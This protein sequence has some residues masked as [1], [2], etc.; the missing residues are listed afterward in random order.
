MA[1]NNIT[2]PDFA[3]PVNVRQNADEQYKIAIKN[4]DEKAALRALVDA[5]L[6]QTAIAPDSA[7]S[8]ANRIE[9]FAAGCKNPAVGSL[10][11][12]F[13]AR[14]YND[15]YSSNRWV[16]NSRSLPEA[17]V[18]SDIQAWDGKM[19]RNKINS[20][21]DSATASLK[22][23]KSVPVTDFKALVT[24]PSDARPFFPTL[25]DFV[26][27]NVIELKTSMLNSNAQLPLS[28]LSISATPSALKKTRPEIYAILHL[29]DELID[30]SR[31]SAAP[32]LYWT[33]EK[34]DFVKDRVYFSGNKE[35]EN[36]YKEM[37]KALFNKYST[38]Q[39]C[40][41]PLNS[42][43]AESNNES[44]DEEKEIYGY[45]KATVAKYPNAPLTNCLKNAMGQLARKSIEINH[46]S[47]LSPGGTLEVKISARNTPAAQLSLYRLPDDF[48][49][50]NN[51]VR[52]VAGAVKTD[53]KSVRFSGEVPFR[54]SDTVGFTIDQP[55]RYV[56]VPSFSGAS[57]TRESYPVIHVSALSAGAFMGEKNKVV[58]VE[59]VSGAPVNDAEIIG[60]RRRGNKPET[61]SLG[62]TDSNGFTIIPANFSGNIRPVK[63]ADRFAGTMYVYEK[64]NST[65]R[66]FSFINLFCDLPVY[67][68]GDSVNWACVAYS[69]AGKKKEVLSGKAVKVIFIDANRTPID[70]AT[71][72]TDALGRASGTFS[73]PEGLLTGRFS[74]RASTVEK[75]IDAQGYMGVMVSDYKLPTYILDELK[76][77]NDT[78]EKGSTTFTGI[79]KTFSGVPLAGISVKMDI[80]LLP[81]WW[82]ASG[83]SEKFYSDETVTDES[84]RF[85]FTV[86]I[87]DYE[88]APN[89]SGAF[90]AYFTATSATGESATAQK[91]FTLGTKYHIIANLPADMDISIPV[92]LNAYACDAEG[93]PVKEPVRFSVVADKDT[94]LRGEFETGNTVDL[95]A[96]PSGIYTFIFD[97]D[98]AAAEGIGNIAVYRPD[99]AMPP[100]NAT[101]W[102][103][104]KIVTDG[105][106]LLI[107]T[108]N[109]VT[110]VLYTIVSKDRTMKQEWL[111]YSPRMHRLEVNLPENAEDAQL[112]LFS[113]ADYKSTTERIRIESRKPSNSI[114]I[115]TETWRD[116]LIPGSKETI[117][118]KVTGADS[119][120]V[121]AA[122]MLDMFN[123]AL[124]TFSNHSLDFNPQTG[125]VPETDFKAPR[126]F[127]YSYTNLYSPFSYLTCTD[128]FTPELNT[129][130]RSFNPIMIRGGAMKL[131]GARSMA[132]G[133]AVSEDAA[134]EPEAVLMESKVATAVT[135]DMAKEESVEEEADAGSSENYGNTDNFDYRDS[136]VPLAF[137]NPMLTTD[138]NGNLSYTFTVPNAN[139]SWILSALAYTTDLRTVTVYKTAIASKPIM[140]TPNL[141]RFVR[142]G[143]EIVIE[144]QVFNTTDNAVNA[145]TTVEIINPQT[146]K[147][148]QTE[149]YRNEIGANSS[150]KV[151]TLLTAATDL[152]FIC[153]R[154]KASA[155]SYADGEQ[156][157][158]PVLP[159]SSP[160]IEST[161]FYIPA[162]ENQFKIQLPKYGNDARVTFTYC[163]NP[164]WY[165]VTALPELQKTNP[166]GAIEV[167]NNIFS[168]AVAQGIVKKYPSI[169]EALEFWR[170][171]PSD[172]ILTSMLERNGDMKSLLLAATP[173][174][175]DA[176][177]DSERMTRLALLLDNKECDNTIKKS[178]KTLTELQT[179][180]GG[181][182]W[183]K[184][185]DR[186]SLWVT[187]SVLK[188]L[189]R[190]NALGFMP[191]DTEL[192]KLIDNGLKYI[193]RE[194]TSIYNKYPDSN[195]RSYAETV[196]LFPAFN[197]STIGRSM[198]AVSTQR[199]VKDWKKMT[200]A[201]KAN[202]AL[203]L[204]R[205]GNKA[206][207]VTILKSLDEYATVT[208]ERG[209]WWQSLNDR[210]ASL[211]SL[212]ATASA[213][214]AYSTI[215]PGVQQ[216]E[217]INQWLILQKQATNW[218]NTAS[219][220]ET[221]AAIL[222]STPQWVK[223]DTDVKIELNE[224]TISTAAKEYTGE[225]KI[226][227]DPRKAS[228]GVL[229]IAKSS[230]APA[231]GGVISFE[232]K[233]M[234]SVKEADC[235]LLSISKKTLVKNGG[236]WKESDTF[237]VGDRVKISLTVT[238]GGVIDYLAITDSRAACLEPVEQL[239]APIW[240]DGICFYREN[241][242]SST[243]IFIDRL[244]KGTFVLEY[245]MWVNNSGE[246]SS[247]IATAQSQYA[248]EIT[249][250]SAGKILTVTE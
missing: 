7:G 155:E 153:F 90:S 226:N 101:L 104:K 82:R 162:D 243:N 170:N 115:S 195:F 131:Y 136:E 141:P 103:P 228:K 247:G 32:Y 84:G 197:P 123:S 221:V 89:T 88:L 175:Q 207:A 69:A 75:D 34:L 16:F 118:F 181:I 212:I 117:T 59:P 51:Y 15:V 67:H 130:N 210:S 50:L 134:E 204:F 126:A 11:Y 215:T 196:S 128:I 62:K 198:I 166:S 96:L 29:Y 80:S 13:T 27:S 122:M 236:E 180:D 248:P 191:K 234:R 65:N 241:R 169:G 129:Y 24:V 174:M 119:A 135:M 158:I 219:T 187:T 186:P 159:S 133:I 184:Q 86:S 157:I 8:M 12:L 21:C 73:I 79:A 194:Y 64:Y 45:I 33:I 179:Q 154:I 77:E 227:F 60:F 165:V 177:S 240:S 124:K 137:F 220:S 98:N 231:W 173:W 223:N 229:T 1:D 81:N 244:P 61:K 57:N 211:S 40:T 238:S 230:T 38:S 149:N 22:S 35:R 39:Y 199:I 150:I 121:K 127:S 49:D 9:R 37:M 239:P 246:F 52:L 43:A 112:W 100:R 201:E 237:K 3:F 4:S 164:V 53:T 113:I 216:I 111:S 87:S 5:S 232:T 76:V 26:V 140:V 188:T 151:S 102:I 71:V 193:Q 70:T 202:A 92:K 44:I 17:P 132:N 58:V 214:T 139:T 156:A 205:T 48:T 31:N 85:T 28:T 168:A 95:S 74:I 144:S 94:V 138:S 120:G 41:L 203:L 222:T 224:K 163:D 2:V 46:N 83:S 208:P 176:Q 19:F 23:I 178:V 242:D 145:T 152:P 42:L 160:V 206:T 72:T 183:M 143:D 93:L 171:N 161:D 14:I 235:D 147:V 189:G 91:S 116:R 190:L 78:P 66:T 107:G 209:M 47:F 146:G 172:S 54:E 125:Y 105:S 114:S 142:T 109:R 20:L 225:V 233:S 18:P 25:A 217:K 250:H 30:N 106:S 68:P 245:E 200:M 218:G 10:A 55:G 213:L 185:Y 249:A 97:A 99:D 110:N 63:G 192:T 108:S 36:R 6:A 167:A 56:I 148:L 182:A